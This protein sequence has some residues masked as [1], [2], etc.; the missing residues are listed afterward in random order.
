MMVE[1]GRTVLTSFFQERIGNKVIVTIA[2]EFVGGV[3]ALDG[4]LENGSHL[5]HVR[6]HTMGDDLVVEGTPSWATAC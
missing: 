3:T 1:G 5:E 6:Y 4:P 2:P